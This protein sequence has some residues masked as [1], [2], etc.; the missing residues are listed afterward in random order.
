[1]F[2]CIFAFLPGQHPAISRSTIRGFTQIESFMNIVERL[3]WTKSSLTASF[4]FF[5]ITALLPPV[6]RAQAPAPQRDQLLNGLRILLWTRP[7]DQNVLLKLQIH[8]GA[9]FDPVGKEG[10]TA[11]LGDILFP[12]A[13]TH[14]YFTQEMGG[15][16]E[17]E[18]TQ[19]VINI[20]LQGRASEYDRIV[21]VL[22]GALVTTPLTA[23]NLATFRNARLK[24]LSETKTSPADLADRLIAERLLG[25]FPYARPV[26][27]AVE[28]LN[29]IERGDLMLAREKFLSPNNATLVIVGGVDRGPAMRALRQLLGGWRRSDQL[30]PATFRQPDPPDQRILIADSSGAA[31][32]EVRLATRSL[33]RSDPDYFASTLLTVIARDR[34]SALTADPKVALVVRQDAHLL[35]GMFL[36][37]AS[38]NGDAA[39]KTLA[40]ARS[41][42]K[43]LADSP[44]A[45]SELESYKSQALTRIMDPR[46]TLEGVAN[47]WLD[48]DTYLLP[49][50]DDQ[51]RA[52]SA[53]S[54]ADLQR[55]AGRLF[56]ETAMAAVVVG[57]A[58]QLKTQLG[59]SSKIEMLG[60]AKPKLA[61]QPA[62][63][64]VK[65]PTKQPPI[66][67]KSPNPFLKDP[68]P[69]TKPD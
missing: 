24:A 65:Q 66:L 33:A 56:R 19:D 26:G 35:P 68:K 48:I 31:T 16:L 64:N 4:L 49:P 52:W 8:S 3:G 63:T 67:P 45:P 34:W 69:I 9:S 5:L 21:D 29:R 6:L 39:P 47:G 11:L 2:C 44:V 10:T 22:R 46:R 50:F 14:D 25:S 15:R 41:V 58:D 40:D 12:D 55:V 18:T 30:T 7:G 38:V 13:S 1:M 17:V 60:E 36:M 20:T 62:K 37:A 23:E 43:S 54:A 61:A 27:G 51:L 28:S 32:A 42:L 53:V 57:A 59:T